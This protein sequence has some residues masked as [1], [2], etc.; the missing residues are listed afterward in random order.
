MK[1]CKRRVTTEIGANGSHNIVRFTGDHHHNVIPI[2]AAVKRAIYKKNDLARNSQLSNREVVNAVR[3]NLP[4]P[5]LALLPSSLNQVRNV[6]RIR[7]VTNGL[8]PEPTS[9]ADVNIPDAE[10]VT[11]VR[12]EFGGQHR[13]SLFVMHDSGVEEGNRRFFIFSCDPLI[14]FL[15]GSSEWFF[16]GTFKVS[17]GIAFQLVAVHARYRDTHQTIPCAYILLPNKTEAIY[18]AALEALKE[19]V[20]NASPDSVMADFEIGLH[21]AFAEVFPETHISAFDGFD[22]Q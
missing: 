12:D 1:K 7:Q 6:C 13:E 11:F 15:R 14:E 19:L 16:D 9:L 5:V 4:A 21:N 10:T 8:P 20:Q 17:P 3:N 22:R 2:V 18:I